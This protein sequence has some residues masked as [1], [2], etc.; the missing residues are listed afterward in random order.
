M[1][2]AKTFTVTS[3]K[4]KHDGVDISVK[5]SKFAFIANAAVRSM[6]FAQSEVGSGIT[7]P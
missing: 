1:L 4:D 2:N 6:C 7:A 3:N 5:A